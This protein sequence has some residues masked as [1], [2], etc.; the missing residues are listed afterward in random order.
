MHNQSI[1]K[2]IGIF[3]SI[4]SASL[5]AGCK[6]YSVSLNNNVVYT[7]PSIFKDFAIADANLRACV[8]QTILDKRISKA[9]DLKQLNCS[10]AGINSLAG[11][12]KFYAIEHLNL[13]ENNIQSIAPITN[14]STLKVLILRKNNLTNA[15]PLLHLLA[16]QEVDVSENEKLA[17]RDLKQLASN[18]QHGNLKLTLPEQCR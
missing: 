16:L 4:L 14:I 2:F 5:M 17:C 6:N 7:P 15:E 13:A 8:E 10:H 12:E 18:F 9:E 1:Y 11:L 3:V